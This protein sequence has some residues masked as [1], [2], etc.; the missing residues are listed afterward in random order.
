MHVRTWEEEALK[1]LPVIEKGERLPRY[2]DMYGGID[3]FNAMTYDANKDLPLG[4]ALAN[5]EDT[6]KSL[7][8]Y[9]ES[10]PEEQFGGRTRFR[11]RLSADTYKHYPEHAEMILELIK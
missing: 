4:T 5:L 9:L 2:R 11:R 10:V 7:V 1:Y 3:S 6:H 8:L